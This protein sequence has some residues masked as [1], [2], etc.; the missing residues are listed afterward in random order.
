M[1]LP[2]PVDVELHPKVLVAQACAQLGRETVSEWCV[3]LLEERIAPDDPCQPSLAWIGG[4]PAAAALRSGRL[5]RPDQSHWPRVWAVRA[6]RYAW[7]PEAA[8]AIGRA[9]TDSSWR[10]REIAAKLVTIHELAESIELLAA[11]VTDEVARVRAASVRGLGAVGESD[12]ANLIRSA[13][14][15]PNPAVAVAAEMALAELGHRLDRDL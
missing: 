8:P 5:A 11:L 3:S 9:L 4:N 12:Y 13:L 15:D 10:V 14:D 1:A 2:V 7:T 6:L